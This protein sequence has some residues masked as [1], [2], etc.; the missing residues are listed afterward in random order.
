MIKIAPSILSAD[1][2]HLGAQLRA[3]EEAGADVLHIDVMDG[4]F[5]PN[6]TIGPFVIKQI[7]KNTKLPLDVHLMI[8]EPGRSI[9][10]YIAAGADYLAVHY[11]AEKHIHRVIHRIKDA[12]VKAAVSINPATSVWVLENILSDIDMALVMSV[13]PG[14][15]GQKFIKSSVE[16]VRTLKKMISERGLSVVIEVDGGVNPQNAAELASAGADILVMGSAFFESKDYART[17]REVRENT[18]PKIPVTI[19]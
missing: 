13:N 6:L 12:G 19:V 2:M 5:V 18:A 16:K 7:K 3:A 9:D 11:E 17:V 8:D 1:F 15:G 10:D 14:F 4:R